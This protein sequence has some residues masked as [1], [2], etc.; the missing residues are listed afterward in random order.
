MRSQHESRD[1]LIYRSSSSCIYSHN[2][3]KFLERKE[4]ICFRACRKTSAANTMFQS[5]EA[6]S[7]CKLR[8]NISFTVRIPVMWEKSSRHSNLSLL[9]SPWFT[10]LLAFSGV[11]PVCKRVYGLTIRGSILATVKIMTRCIIMRPIVQVSRI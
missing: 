11:Q 8:T 3:W 9:R 4:G 10:T 1:F 7:A 5:K 2:G 6:G